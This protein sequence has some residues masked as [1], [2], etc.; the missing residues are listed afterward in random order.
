MPFAKSIK[1]FLMD[2]D[3]NGRCLCELSNWSGIAYKIPRI[4]IKQ[5][6]DRP[7]LSNPGIYFLFGS[8]LA[9]DMPLIYIGESE[10][11]VSRLKQHIEEK[12][13]WNEAIIFLSKD[14]HLNKAHIK[15]LENIF[16]EIARKSARYKIVNNNIPKKSIISE[17]ERAELEEFVYN[18]KIIVNILGHKV[19]EELLVARINKNENV[20]ANEIFY[21]K[22]KSKDI[23]ARGQYSSEGFVVY[24]GSTISPS[25][26]KSIPA[27][28]R[29]L[30]LRLSSNGKI[31]DN[32][33]IEDTLF[34]SP[35]A[36]SDCILG[37]NSSGPQNWN[38][39]DII[40]VPLFDGENSLGQGA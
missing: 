30:R 6:N 11:I 34:S 27:G 13:F 15:Y 25:E 17:S 24:K 38:V 36:A 32:K 16:H 14:D 39:T 1:I 20:N 8:D 19:F 22:S 40:K 31:V 18:A 26:S 4:M 9:A 12:D 5:C 37:Y 7:E 2:G 10:D 23:S 33:F 35:S 21:I 3:P 28:A 29:K